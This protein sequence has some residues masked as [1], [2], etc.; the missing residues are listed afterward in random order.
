MV[1][2]ETLLKNLSEKEKEEV[3]KI[4]NELSNEGKSKTY[5][6]I[7]Y[8]DYNEIPVDI[9]TFLTD[10]NYL[11]Q[12]WKDATG[13]SKLYPFWL[14]QLKKLFPTNLDTD[15][16]TLL[17]SGAR[18]IGKSEIACGAVGAYLMYRILCLKNPLEY[19][20]LKPTEKICFGFMNIKL[21]L[22]EE[23]AISKF[24]K[25]V[26]LSPWF[27]SKGTMTTFH[28]SNYWV[29][30]DPIN[31]IIGSQ[32]DDL[33]G[34]AIFWCLDGNTPILTENGIFKIKDLEN[35]KIKVPTISDSGSVILS[36]ECT[37]KQTVISDTE[38]EIELED[39]TILKCT[40]THRF[41]L[42]NGEYKEAQNLTENDEILDFNPYGYI[43]KTT[44]LVNGKIYIGQHKGSYLDSSYFGSGFTLQKAILKYGVNN[45]TC[46]ILELCSNKKQL[47][48]KEKFY[49]SQFNST[50][51]KIGYNISIGGV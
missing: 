3:F 31:I 5:D 42:I 1:Y 18:G 40:P 47:D 2:D 13:K 26:Q 16:N 27:M 8:E 25:T 48:D 23:I 30:P 32:S 9:E 38:Y 19:Y 20:H 45:F 28:G 44:N 22:A 36:D 21:S 6:T 29:P 24:Q 17:E 14:E 43:Y 34:Q 15:Y 39:G 10:D 33:I 4:L 46:E 35:Q 7:L 50:N 11:G 41:R 49:I 37:V 12:A 51:P